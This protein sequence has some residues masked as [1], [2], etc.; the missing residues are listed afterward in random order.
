MS[1][2]EVRILVNLGPN[3]DLLRMVISNANKLT[4]L[5]HLMFLYCA[6][7]HLEYIRLETKSC[8]ISYGKLTVKYERTSNLIV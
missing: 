7:L 8:R 2:A 6:L 3:N 4:T 5:Y 1:N